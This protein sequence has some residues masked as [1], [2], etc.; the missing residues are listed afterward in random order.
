[1]HMFS[2]EK[3]FYGGHGIVGAQ[4][5]L[6]TGLAFANRYRE[7]RQC[8][9]G[10]FRRRRRQ[11]G[12]GLRK[13]Q[14]GRAV[15]AAGHLRRREQP[16]CDG[17]LGQPLLGAA[18]FLQARRVVRYSGRAGRR[19]GRARGEGR[20]RESRR[21]GAARA[22]GPTSSKCR[23][24]AIAATR[25]R[26]RRNTARARRS[27][28]CATIRIRSSRCASALLAM[29]V[30]EDELKK[31]DA[32]VRQIVNRVRR[33]RAERSGAGCVRALDRRDA[34]SREPTMPVQILMPALSPTMEKGNLAKWLK[35]EGDTVKSGDVIAE[36][37]TDKATMEVEATDEG[38]L[39]QDP[40][41][42]RHAGRR[43]QHADRNDPERRR[44]RVRDPCIDAAERA[45][46]GR[47]V[48][49]A[50]RRRQADDRC[51][52]GRERPAGRD[53][54]RSRMCRQAP[55]W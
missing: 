55:R 8:E 3:H 16:L 41:A 33:L 53:S 27:R 36:I 7:Q 22:T 11:P 5:S 52:G 14:H 10:L 51:A 42:G 45:P 20:G 26:I 32:E 15:E 39:G 18:G 30:R 38:T 49:L 9:P 28:R 50:G 17:H 44:G 19:H 43:R 29:N 48:A 6:G 46:R 34:L 12:P 21:S 24:I 31:I 54:G 2:T 47:G 25:C 4:V 35:K 37:E 40:R 23:P 1:M 13:L